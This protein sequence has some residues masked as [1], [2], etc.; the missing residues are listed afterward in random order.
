MFVQITNSNI[1]I[2]E[3]LLTGVPK[4]VVKIFFKLVEKHQYRIF[5]LVKMADKAI[6]NLR[7]SMEFS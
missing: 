2:V 3:Q 7:F 5:F 4:N 1:S 6:F